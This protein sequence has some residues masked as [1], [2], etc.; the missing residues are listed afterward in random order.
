MKILFSIFFFIINNAM[1]A[2]GK[3]VSDTTSLCSNS[4]IKNKKSFEQDFKY[5][6]PCHWVK[7]YVFQP[8]V[9]KAY[10]KTLSEEVTMNFMISAGKIGF[11]PSKNEIKEFWNEK[12]FKKLAEQ[13]GKYISGKSVKISN[14]DCAEVKSYTLKKLPTGDTHVFMLNYNLINKDVQYV[15]SFLVMAPTTEES[16]QTFNEYESLFKKIAQTFSIINN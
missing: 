16:Q 15:F 14:Y 7:D 4:E 2:Q 12:N 6:F 1:F 9:I 5:S 10:S 11:T 3:L 13:Y 8:N